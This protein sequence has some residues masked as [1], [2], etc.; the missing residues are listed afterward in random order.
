[1]D[2][3]THFKPSKDSHHAV[4]RARTAAKRAGLTEF[5]CAIFGGM[6]YV[7]RGGWW[8]ASTFFLGSSQVEATRTLDDLHRAILLDGALFRVEDLLDPDE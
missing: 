7:P 5:N 3:T 4:D 2:P 1:M 8:L 6:Y